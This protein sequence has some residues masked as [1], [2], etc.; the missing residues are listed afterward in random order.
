MLPCSIADLIA[1]RSSSED[2]SAL[3][4]T[5]KQLINV[6][7]TEYLLYIYLRSVPDS[8]ANFSAASLCPEMIK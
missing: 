7:E 5:T 1:M 2:K 6:I 3:A 4:A 8:L